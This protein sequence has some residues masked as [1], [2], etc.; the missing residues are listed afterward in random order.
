M[1]RVYYKMLIVYG[2]SNNGEFSNMLRNGVQVWT[3]GLHNPA[4]RAPD[5]SDDVHIWSW[6]KSQT[7]LWTSAGVYVVDTGGSGA[8]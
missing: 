3:T 7:C 5:V 2:D 8:T 6:T 1:K 4:E